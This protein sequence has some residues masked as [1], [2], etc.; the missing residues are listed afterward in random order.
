MAKHQVI[1][2]AIQ[3]DTDEEQEQGGNFT[4]TRS[5]RYRSRDR[6]WNSP[7]KP[8]AK[9]ETR[10]PRQTAPPQTNFNHTAPPQPHFNHNTMVPALDPSLLNLSIGELLSSPTDP[11][12]YDMEC[13]ISKLR[14]DLK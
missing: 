4:R 1:I 2:G 12:L 6:G 10:L 9:P 14:L 11:R 8:R 5:E 13:E 3:V 7:T